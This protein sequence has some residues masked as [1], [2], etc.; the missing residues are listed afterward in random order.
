M[1]ILRIGVWSVVATLCLT[2]DVARAAAAETVFAG[3]FTAGDWLE[4]FNRAVPA[5]WVHGID[6]AEIVA[7]PRG[8]VLKVSY[9]AHE[10]GIEQTGIQWRTYLGRSLEHATLTYD[11]KFAEGFDFVKGG[12]LPGLVGG[13]RHGERHSTVS[14]GYRPDGTDGFSCRVMWREDGSVAQYVYHPDQPTAF[15]ELFPWRNADHGRVRFVPG[16]WHRVRTQVDLNDVGARNGRIRSWIDG[17]KVLD[18]RG[19][20][21]RTT[22]T[23]AIDSFAFATF[24]G[25]D[26]DTWATSKSE[27]AYFD[28]FRVEAPVTALD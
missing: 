12:K 4:Q 13:E 26:D 27:T 28:R 8:T 3:G 11:V 25:G 2:P 5:P 22:Q 16:R 15:G 17:S 23:L 6:R 18:V 20:A 24:F 9:P 14:G 10:Y 21:F 19:F 7:D 1:T